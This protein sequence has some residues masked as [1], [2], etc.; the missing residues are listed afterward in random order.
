MMM[1]N[2]NTWPFQTVEQRR[3]RFR[4]LNGCDSRFLILDFSLIPGVDVW[5]IGNEGGFLAAPVSITGAGNR[6]LMAPA[7]RADVIVDFTSV[8]AGN[9]V[10][11]NVG[12]DEPFGGGIPGVDFPV[13]D[14]ATT[15]QIM[16]FRVVPA[17]A[18]DPTTPPQFLVLPPITPLPPATVIRRLALLEELSRFFD[19]APVET[20]LGIVSGDPNTGV[21]TWTKLEWRMPVTENPMVGATEVWEL[22][23]A[24]ADAHPI[25]I[26]EVVF[27]VVNRQD[28]FVDEDAHQVEVVPGSTPTSPEPW[29]TGFKDTVIAY[30]GQVTRVRAQFN[31]PGQ[32]V[33]H[34]HIVEHE[35]NEMMRPYRIG[36]VQPGAPEQS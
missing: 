17:V 25:H 19:D 32:F 31:T 15:G 1:V 35:D 28:I 18:A 30:P 13:A 3:Y 34:C 24:T 5:Q 27:E 12:P 9:H 21:G 6:L 22:Y 10:L 7:E 11:G 29:E 23:N 2:G 16:Q 8:P 26:H 20:E 36:P 14:S 4:F 33:W